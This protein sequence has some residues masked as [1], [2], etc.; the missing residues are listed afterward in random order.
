VIYPDAG[1][2]AALDRQARTNLARELQQLRS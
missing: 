2:A 1:F